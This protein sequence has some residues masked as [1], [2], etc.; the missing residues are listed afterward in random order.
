MGHAC[1]VYA[2]GKR[3]SLFYKEQICWGRIQGTNVTSVPGPPAT[4]VAAVPPDP[5]WYEAGVPTDTALG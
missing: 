1:E 2:T 4:H 5:E 3:V